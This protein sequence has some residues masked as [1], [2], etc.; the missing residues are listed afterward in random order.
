VEPGHPEREIP[1]ATLRLLQIAALTSTCDRFAIA[2]LL[3]VIGRDLG[4][5]LAAVATMA[6]GYFLAYGLMQPVWGLLSDRLGRVRVMRVALAG[7]ALGGV[8]STLAPNLVVLSASR[9]LAGGMVAAL[10]PASLVYVGDVWPAEVRQRPLSDVL[11]ASAFG[12]AVATVGAGLL[13]ELVGWRAVFGVVGVA[14]AALW[15]ALRQLPEPVGTARAPGGNPLG[16]IGQVLVSGWAW[17]VLVLALVEGVVV[18]GTL[19]YLAPALQS[20]GWSAA[21]AGLV[22]AGFGVGALVA[23]RLVRRLV[24]RVRP[25]GLAAIGGGFLAVTWVPPAI[26]VGIVT[27]LAAGLLLGGSWAFLH[28]TLQAWATEVVPRARAAAVAL[29]A[30][31]LFVGSSVGT[32]LGAPLADAGAY[33]TLFAAALLVAVPLAV[34]A[35]LARAGYGRRAVDDPAG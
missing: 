24:G 12:T 26:D 14:S 7:T 6:G 11:A 19:T 1:G 2:P 34:A 31:V 29:F 22:A 13:A 20:Q 17:V 33:R 23:S 35:A 4:V 15:F 30:A 8:L 9:V 10:I 32:A 18:L 5:S 3:V 27:V 16:S 21:V 28:S 25:A